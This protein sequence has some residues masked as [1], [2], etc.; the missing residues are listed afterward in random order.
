MG[1][2]ARTS[3]TKYYRTFK[4]DIV[5]PVPA[6]T[7]NAKSRKKKDSEEMIHELH[8][9]SISGWIKDFF[10]KISEHGGKKYITLNI[11]LVDKNDVMC[12]QVSNNSGMA[13][14]FYYRLKNV[15]FNHEV[16]ICTAYF[17]EKDGKPASS[18]M[19]IK[20]GDQNVPRFWND[21]NLPAP[22]VT[23]GFD[24][25]QQPI[26]KYDWTERS[27]FI[28]N[29]LQDEIL[30][31]LGQEPK[32]VRDKPNLKPEDLPGNVNQSA[33]PVAEAPMA[34]HIGS[35]VYP[36]AEGIKPEKGSRTS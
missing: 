26:K 30:P 23:E 27:A 24:E 31:L 18:A 16:E 13:R 10:V 22:K 5:L 34:D 7:P 36:E 8:Y 28:N 15:N 33:A 19:W 12:L 29:H 20:Q 17:P 4:G 9:G 11:Y 35:S 2:N 21:D 3:N 32:L 1:A 14:G 6:G 25:L